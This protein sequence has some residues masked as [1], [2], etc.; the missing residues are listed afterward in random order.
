[1]QAGGGGTEQ[2]YGLTVTWVSVLQTAA[3]EPS[4]SAGDDSGIRDAEGLNQARDS[5]RGEGV[6]QPRDI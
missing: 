6:L 3:G 2:L 5:D 4:G 1:M